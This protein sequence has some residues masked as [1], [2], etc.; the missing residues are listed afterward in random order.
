LEYKSD[1][2]ETI[3]AKSIRGL[4]KNRD[5][6]PHVLLNGNFEK[7]WEGEESKDSYL[8]MGGGREQGGRKLEKDQILP[9]LR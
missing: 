8:F 3:E 6:L 5:R 4:R 1:A 2:R 7:K 9:L